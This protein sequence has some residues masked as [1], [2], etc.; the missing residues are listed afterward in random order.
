MT[1]LVHCNKEEYD[2][3]IGRPSKWGN[4]YTHIADKETLAEF[5]V[6]T[7]EEAI[8]KYSDY[9]KNKPELM[10]ALC[11]L[12][13]KVLGCWCSPKSCHGDILIQLLTQKK[14]NEF[15]NK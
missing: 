8:A 7:R 4:P 1:R 12:E 6:E 11:E 2:V 3:Y 9:I 5:I 15:F 13:G 10:N 14:L